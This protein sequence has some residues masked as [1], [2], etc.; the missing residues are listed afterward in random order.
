MEIKIIVSKCLKTVQN[1]LFKT[2]MDLDCIDLAVVVVPVLDDK[3]QMDHQR[4]L[5]DKH[6]LVYDLIQY[7]WLVYHKYLHMDQHIDYLDKPWLDY[8]PYSL[9]ILVDNQ[10]MDH[11]N[12]P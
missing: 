12:S 5:V 11:Q 4:I 8:I 6:S 10:Y 3:Q 1:I 7:K 9:Y 2:H